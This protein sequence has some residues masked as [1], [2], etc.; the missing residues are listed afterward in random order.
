[1]AFDGSLFGNGALFEDSGSLLFWE[2]GVLLD[3][4][5]DFLAL[6]LTLTLLLDLTAVFFGS[7]FYYLV[8]VSLSQLFGELLLLLHLVLLRILF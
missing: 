6:L 3:L 7:Y 1:M 8:I 5:E 4:L 2:E